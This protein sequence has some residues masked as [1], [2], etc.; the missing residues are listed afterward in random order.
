MKAEKM[1]QNIQVDGEKLGKVLQ[2]VLD[3]AQTT[4]AYE[5]DSGHQRTITVET[6]A[7]TF[8]TA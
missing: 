8:G 5:T 2:I 1:M 7:V 6:E 4:I 3:A